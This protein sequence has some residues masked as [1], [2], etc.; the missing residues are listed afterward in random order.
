MRASLL[1]PYAAYE[2]K[3]KAVTKMGMLI[4]GMGFRGFVEGHA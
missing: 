4:V 3:P 2:P 1:L